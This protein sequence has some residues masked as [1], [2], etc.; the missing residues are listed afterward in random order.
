MLARSFQFSVLVAFLFGAANANAG[1]VI[2]EVMYNPIQG[3]S[4][5]PQF[6]YEWIEIA[7]FGSS[8]VDLSDYELAL[9]IQDPSD[10]AD[11]GVELSFGPLTGN[12]ASNSSLVLYAAEYPFDDGLNID[13]IANDQLL[14]SLGLDSSN[15]LG[16]EPWQSLSD[17]LNTGSLSLHLT[18]TSVPDSFSLNNFNTDTSWPTPEPG[19][20]IFLDNLSGTQGSD[21]LATTS[22]NLVA[23]NNFGLSGTEAGNFGSPGLVQFPAGPP[24]T[25]P[26]PTSLAIFA[27]L[28][29][30][31]VGLRRRR[32]RRES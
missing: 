29:C 3:D 22:E 9:Q 23:T 14:V 25:V 31:T 30:G 19:H 26:E 5:I 12:L 15:S 8:S 24:A 28:I 10:L 1:L 27:G 17:Q 32:S 4:D 11:S 7:N 18:S 6:A 13:I 2:S 21:W 16:L 20:S